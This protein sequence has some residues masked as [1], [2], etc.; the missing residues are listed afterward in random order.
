MSAASTGRAGARF[1]VTKPSK[2]ASSAAIVAPGT[3][4]CA[5]KASAFGTGRAG[6]GNAALAPGATTMWFS[7]DGATQMNARPVGT[8]LSRTQ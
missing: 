4:S 2:S 8:V 1:S 7:P 6:A 5:M 3:S